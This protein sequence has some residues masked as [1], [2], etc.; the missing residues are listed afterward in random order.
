MS[1]S[2]LFRRPIVSGFATTLLAVAFFLQACAGYA[3]PL[4]GKINTLASVASESCCDTLSQPGCNDL[5][6][7]AAS[8]VCARH[9][10]QTGHPAPSPTAVSASSVPVYGSDA[11]TGKLVFLAQRPTLSLAPRAISNTPLIYH[12]QRLLN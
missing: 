6:L 1:L 2:L 10:V 12:L 4:P 11:Y 8:D 5:N 7:A 3:S 9:C